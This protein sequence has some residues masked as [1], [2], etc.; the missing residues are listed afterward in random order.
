MDGIGINN[1]YQVNQQPYLQANRALDRISA[2][3]ALNQASDD[4]SG[5]ALLNEL[6]TQADGFAQAIENMNSG[7]AM[8]NI[9]DNAIGQ[10]TQSLDLIKQQMVQAASDTTSDE[11][12]TAL[13][14]EMQNQL[15]NIDNIGAQTNYNGK[16]LLQNSPDDQGEGWDLN[17]QAGIESSDDISVEGVQA[18]SQGLG[19]ESLFDE[20]ADTFTA[21]AARDYLSKIDDAFTSLNTYRS[22]IGSATNQLESANRGL[23]Q[24]MISTK[25]AASTVGDIDYAKE[26]SNF[27]KQNILGQLGAFAQAQGNDINQYTVSRLLRT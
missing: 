23:I 9:A 13:L 15:K 18:N 22:D 1:N 4:P 17:F 12:R 10:Q 7:V 19:L 26:V 25:A 27:S 20:T 8:M 14:Q 2:G 11:G 5:L 6:Q 21:E 16:T 3:V 24:Q